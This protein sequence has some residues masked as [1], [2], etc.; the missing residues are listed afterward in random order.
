MFNNILIITGT[1]LFIIS[2]FLITRFL[3]LYLKESLDYDPDFAQGGLID[4]RHGIIGEMHELE[5]Y[6]SGHDVVKM[7]MITS[8]WYKGFYDTNEDRF[9]KQENIRQI[10]GYNTKL[11]SEQ[12]I[13]PQAWSDVL[14]FDTQIAAK[15]LAKGLAKAMS[16]A[17]KNMRR[18]GGLTFIP[19]R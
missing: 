4:I 7:S 2:I 1:V 10:V 18:A 14:G 9:Y 13:K 11:W 15:G 17:A 8:E 19:L 5:P 16:K 3:V 12:N 6:I